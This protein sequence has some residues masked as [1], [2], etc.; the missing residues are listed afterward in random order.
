MVGAGNDKQ[1]KLLAE[2]VLNRP[3]LIQDP[4]FVTNQD[5]VKNRLELTQ[6]ITDV[7]LTYN[8]DYWLK[9]FSGIGV[10]F[11]PINNIE[12]TFNHP[13]TAARKMITD[14]QHPRAGGIKLVA[15]AV[16]Y[17]SQRM[18][19]RRYPPVLSEHTDEVLQEI[20]YTCTEI[21][22]LRDGQII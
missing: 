19:V 9:Q 4:R 8:Q 6:I 17:N 12:Q 22:S 1:F 14:M 16:S 3:G 20:G 21:K 18:P 15:P 10:P 13:Q 2:K 11:G 7:F 5:R